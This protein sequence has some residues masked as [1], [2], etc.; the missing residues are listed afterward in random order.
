MF[1]KIKNKTKKAFREELTPLPVNNSS[2][3]SDNS[4][5]FFNIY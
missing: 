5:D 2:S 3:K 4:L 1:K